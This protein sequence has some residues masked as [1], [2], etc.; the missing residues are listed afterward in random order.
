MAD[1]AFWGEV[2]SV[3]MGYRPFEFINDV[4]NGTSATKTQIMYRAFLAYKQ[5]EEHLLFLIEDGLLHYD[6]N[7]RTYRTTENGLRFLELN[8]HIE[9][10]IKYEHKKNENN[11]SPI[12]TEKKE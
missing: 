7:T 10:M 12:G 3:A 4:T 5:S 9:D 8:N 11:N 1:L 6:G 2:I